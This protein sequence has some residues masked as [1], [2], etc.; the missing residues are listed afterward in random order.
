MIKLWIAFIFS[1]LIIVII[2]F[3]AI[4]PWNTIKWGKKTMGIMVKVSVVKWRECC[5]FEVSEFGLQSYDNVP[6]RTDT[7]G[8]GVNLFI[9]QVMCWIIS[10]LFF[11]KYGFGIWFGLVWFHGT[12]TI[13]GYLMP[14][15]F[16]YIETFPFKTIQFSISTQFQCQKQLYFK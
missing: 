12:T 4:Y 15:P 13:I 3:M 11:Y 6:F 8:K 14:N 1:V 16:L 2:Q 10:L 5:C 7:F 9:P